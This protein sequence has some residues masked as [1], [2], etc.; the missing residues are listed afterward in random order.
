M[1]MAEPWFD[2]DRWGW[3]PWTVLAVAGV[4]WGVSFAVL[5][6]RG[7]GRR[8]VVT[9]GWLLL[10]ASAALLAAGFLALGSDQPH[11]VWYGLVLAGAIGMIVFGLNA[12]MASK[13][14]RATEARRSAARDLTP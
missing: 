1:A 2:A 14:Y 3:L 12:P 10:A 6:P 5:G 9:T 13:V 11:R 4:I 7:K 8:V